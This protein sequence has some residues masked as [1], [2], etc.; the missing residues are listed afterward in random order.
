MKVFSFGP[1]QNIAGGCVS[2]PLQNILGLLLGS[3]PACHHLEID[4]GVAC[5]YFLAKA[6]MNGAST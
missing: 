3:Y 6:G 1:S 5:G 2:T 4:D